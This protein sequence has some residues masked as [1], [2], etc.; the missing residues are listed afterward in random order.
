MP[1]KINKVRLQNIKSFIDQSIEFYDGVNF[2]SGINGSGKSTIIESIGFALFNVKPVP[3]M[4]ELVRYGEGIGC[5]SIWFEANDERE[6]CIVRRFSRNRNIGW[7]I[8]DV[9][10]GSELD[11]HGEKDITNWLAEYLGIGIDTEPD[12]VFKDIVGVEQGMFTAPFLLPPQRRT[13]LFNPILKVDSYRRAFQATSQ[14]K[15]EMELK[16]N[17]LTNEIKFNQQRVENYDEKVIELNELNKDIYN[18]AKNKSLLQETLNLRQNKYNDLKKIKD[19]IEGKTKEK[20]KLELE[21]KNLESSLEKTDILIQEAEEAKNIVEA[22]NEGYLKYKSLE[23]ELKSL[24]LARREREKIEQE[25]NKLDKQCSSL[26]A[27]ISSEE[28]NIKDQQIEI[29]SKSIEIN[30]EKEELNEKINLANNSLTIKKSEAQNIAKISEGIENFQDQTRMLERNFGEIKRKIS[31]IQSHEEELGKLNEK[32]KDYDKYKFIANKVNELRRKLEEKNNFIV[33]IKERIKTA[34]ENKERA[35]GGKCPFLGEDCKNV[36]GNLEKYFEDQIEKLRESLNEPKTEYMHIKSELE[37]AESASK[38]ITAMDK[39]KERL[40][41]LKKRKSELYDEIKVTKTKINI[42]IIKDALA[43]IN[44]NLSIGEVYNKVINEIDD[45]FIDEPER[46]DAIIKLLDDYIRYARQS[47][48]I[49]NSN[50]QNELGKAKNEIDSLNSRDKSLEKEMKLLEEKQKI[51]DKKKFEINDKKEMF[52]RK[53]MELQIKQDEISKYEGL[54]DKITKAEQELNACKQDYEKNVRNQ[55]IA[56]K[57]PELQAQKIEII[58][59]LNEKK[60]RVTILA[61]EIDELS[62]HFNAEDYSKLD[63]EIKETEDEIIRIDMKLDQNKKDKDKLVDEITK[64]DEVK[65]HIRTL[66]EKL[67]NYQKAYEILEFIRNSIL[68]KAG[69][70]IADIY[71]K[72]ISAKADEIYRQVSNENVSLEWEDEYEVVLTIKSGESIRRKVFKQLSGGEQMSAALAIRLALLRML[73]NVKIGIFDE[74]TTNMDE[75]RRFNLAQIIPSVTKD[76]KQLFVISHDDSF[77][78]ITENVIHLQK[79]EEAGTVLVYT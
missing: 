79:T 32:L 60:N 74:P 50:I 76:F 9:E 17:D 36:G 31:D 46:Y 69:D 73:S 56:E 44:N 10:T 41:S 40:Q 38:I 20:E 29:D 64:M 39:D 59:E 57:L 65:E 43:R 52:N 51:I 37:N 58:N 24:Q 55:S 28:Q 78:S 68:N 62:H 48:E 27:E 3:T 22:T 35:K 5:I 19:T 16:I 26:E 47:Y 18:L 63:S 15:S 71:R 30:K 67:R 53:K 23:S 12:K 42:N 21:I 75:Q 14:C 77:D 49:I 13:D 7:E 66:E 4:G 72:N 25:I 54:D 34:Q 11:L 70:R 8:Y 33:E 45:R 2:I 6:Y 61:K 1:M